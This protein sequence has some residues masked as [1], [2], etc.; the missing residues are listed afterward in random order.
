LLFVDQRKVAMKAIREILSKNRPKWRKIHMD[1][2]SINGLKPLTNGDLFRQSL[3][4]IFMSLC[5]L[6]IYFH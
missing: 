1:S 5:P 2:T 4:V 3:D 6:F